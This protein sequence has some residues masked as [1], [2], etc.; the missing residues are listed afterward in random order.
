MDTFELVAAPGQE[1]RSLDS[2]AWVIRLSFPFLPLSTRGWS[3]QQG[4]SG[5]LL[6]HVSSCF[7]EPKHSV[8][9]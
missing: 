8:I 9:H 3:S 4:P 2:Q 7:I 5:D 1:F 6:S